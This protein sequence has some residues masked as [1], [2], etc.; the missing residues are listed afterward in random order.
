MN[1]KQKILYEIQNNKKAKNINTNS[2]NNVL[3][4]TIFNSK[5]YDS[6]IKDGENC[7]SIFSYDRESN[8]N[9]NKDDEIDKII[10]SIDFNLINNDKKE[11][12]KKENSLSFL[13]NS[14]FLINSIIGFA[15]KL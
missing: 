10:N 7:L 2:N 15:F 11:R 14:A 6:I 4:N 3:D 13:G 1:L 9:D 8:Y 5:V 12:A